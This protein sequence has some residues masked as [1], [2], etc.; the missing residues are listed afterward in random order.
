MTKGNVTV[1]IVLLAFL[2]ASV[3]LM[4]VA[5][6]RLGDVG[7]VAAGGVSEG[8]GGLVLGAMIAGIVMSLAVGIGL[9]FLVFYS[10]RQGYDEP[11]R[12]VRKDE[13]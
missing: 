7:D 13:E 2:A 1:A 9:M 8:S 3:W 5:W 10:N 4:V 11:G 6:N 12:P